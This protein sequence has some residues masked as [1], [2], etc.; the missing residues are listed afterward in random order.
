MPIHKPEK[1]KR[2]CLLLL[3]YMLCPYALRAEERTL[4]IYSTNDMHGTITPYDKI[5]R[6]ME[7]ERTKYPNTLLLSGGDMFSGNPVVDQYPQRGMPIIDLMNLAGYQYAV[8]GNHEFDYGQ[9]ALEVCREQAKFELL[10]A[11]MQVDKDKALLS[12][13]QPYALVERDDIRIAILGLTETSHRRKDGSL[14]PGANP[15]GMEGIHFEDPIETALKYRYLRQECDVFIALTHLGTDDDKKLAEAM[16]ELDLIV[17]GHSHT[18]ISRTQ[19]TNGM[20][21]TQAEEKLNYINKVTLTLDGKIITGRKTELIKVETLEKADPTATSL[22]QKFHQE[23]PLNK[24]LAEVHAQF[25]GIQSLGML[26]ADALNS[27]CGTDFAF[28]NSGGVRIKVLPKGTIT[29]G[30]IYRMDP[31]KNQI[32]TLEMTPDEIRVL[33]MNS[34]Q[35]GSQQADLLPAGMK[36]TLHTRNGE[37]IG[38]T[39]TDMQGQPLDENKRYKVSMNGYIAAS[40]RFDESI[41]RQEMETTTDAALI[42][43]LKQMGKIIPQRRSRAIVMEE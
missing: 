13:P 6:F 25:D 42:K 5:V 10:C 11:N 14:I 43:Y 8:P 18:R 21:I 32:V 12:Q 39:L 38:V 19:L 29:L 28:Q 16:P 36:Y 35:K 9:K 15:M 7:E 31:F 20:L 2:F 17:G 3:L 1:M 30:D 26:M 23:M 27:F 40:Y 37:A 22:I 4:V 34:H 33:L 41:P 24:P